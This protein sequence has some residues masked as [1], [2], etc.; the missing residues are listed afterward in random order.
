MKRMTWIIFGWLVLNVT[1]QAAS[2][3][4]G[5]VQTKVEHLIC[6]NPEISKLDEELNAAYK[7]ALQDEKQADI[8]KQAQKRWIKYRNNC[9]DADCVK[10]AYEMRLSSLTVTHVYEFSWGDMSEKQKGVEFT[11]GSIDMRKPGYPFTL[12]EGKGVDVC[13]IYKKN[14]EALGNPNLACERRVSSE[15]VGIIKLPDWRKLDLWENRNLWAQ[16]EAVAA[17]GANSEYPLETKND[18]ETQREVDR[19]AKRYQEH[20]EQY[21]EETYQISLAEMDVDNDGRKETVLREVSGLCG[22]HAHFKFIA[23]FVLDKKGNSVDVP[24]SRP[25]Y[26]DSESNPWDTEIQESGTIGNGSMYDMFFFK[27]KTYFDRWT[28]TGIW[29]YRISNGQAEAVC[30]LK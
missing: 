9:K 26:Q 13:E 20:A 22:Q 7:T 17:V 6:D 18:A 23:L 3:D 4:C 11:S 15:Y 24:K 8:I 28:W 10:H 30:H 27:D 16:V 5:K 2:F 12:G 29:I 1:A 19:L 14:L 25:L 21:H